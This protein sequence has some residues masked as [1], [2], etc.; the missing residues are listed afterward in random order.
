MFSS[1][2]SQTSGG[3][4]IQ[5]SLR[6]N[7]ADSAYLNRTFSTNGTS[8]TKCTISLWIKLSS[9]TTNQYRIIDCYNGSSGSSSNIRVESNQIV[10][11]FGGGSSAEIKTSAV[12][13]DFSAW[14]HIVCSIDSTQAT[15]TDR[16]KLYINGSQITAFA[17]SSYP[18]QNATYNFMCGAAT[19]AIGSSWDIPSPSFP[20]Y[21]NCY[22]TEVN[23]IDGQALTPSSFG[24]FD[25]Q[26]GVWGPTRYAGSYG[27][28]GF[29][30]NFS[31]NS[32]TTAATLGKD[33]SPN[34]N[35]W[36]PNNFSV[37]AG[38]GNDS[39]VDVPTNW[40][41]D[42]GV[43]GTVRGNYCT[44]N[45]L[46][47]NR[48][49]LTNG[50]LDADGSDLKT[51]ISTIGVSTGKWYW[52][53]LIRNGTDTPNMGVTSF[54][55]DNADPGVYLGV[56]RSYVSSGGGG[57][58]YKNY[59]ATSTVADADFSNAN[60]AG[61]TI[62]FALDCDAG[63]LS[64][65]VNNVLGYTDSTIA[66]GTLLYP[67]TCNFNSAANAYR[68]TSVNFGQRPFA[69]T[70]P[71]GFR[72]LNTQ[73]LPTPT[74]G[75]T[76]A[77][78]AGKFFN[79]VLYTGTGSSRTVTGVGF[80]PDWTWIKSRSNGAYHHRL[81]DA[82]RGVTKEIYSNLTNA[83]GTDSVGLTAFGSDGF[84]VGSSNEYN[85]SGQTF[86]AWNWRA[87]GTGVTNTAGS[88]TS[89]VSANTTSGFSIARGTL[90]SSG[91]ASYGHGL[92]VAPSFIFAK[93]TSTTSDWFVY[94]TSLGFNQDI[95]LNTASAA[96]STTFTYNS[97][98]ASTVTIGGG[99]VSAFW[100]ANT[101]WVWYNF[102][103][104]PG[105][106]RFGNY[107][108][109]GSSDGPFVFCGFRPAYVMIKCS[110]ASGTQWLL[111][112]STRNPSNVVGNALLANLSDA[113]ST[114]S[115][116]CDFLSNGFKPRNVSSSA[117]TNGATY[118]FMAFASAPQKFALAR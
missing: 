111:L 95:R 118:I 48:P 96:S 41:V 76:T 15:S 2:T 25:A 5:R 18:S 105:Y 49:T 52:E 26:T 88:I 16:M 112:D 115:T 50:N 62:G 36:T 78:Q 47:V 4:E 57:G 80:Q 104:V 90:P 6:F 54:P 56:G 103:E 68:N 27:T 38:A 19:N 70:A 85:A 58:V 8:Q 9:T 106:S 17:S 28:N 13:R 93:C 91:G 24:A 71:S 99:N 23:F 92:G 108:G 11:A 75:A 101:T 100:G 110:S 86:V 67:M 102:A 39:L 73:N 66:T 30:L 116:W 98:S 79:P 81:T 7:S 107:T 43:G 53:I 40:G 3:Y 65:Y 37:S 45:P 34:G 42:T 74:I 94:H 89:T 1:N 55:N 117:N 59:T 61:A 32:N 87:N 84:T 21:S 82:V 35:N 83:E 69:Y 46:V 97:A 10:L 20:Y 14:Y 60:T 12:F 33:Y 51:A 44:W 64:Y 29:Y 63:T 114:G 31:D 72:A 22:L 113:E 77:T 109:N